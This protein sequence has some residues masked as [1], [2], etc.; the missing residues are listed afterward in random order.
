MNR[1]TGTYFGET[2]ARS[3]CV[4]SLNH[5][6][7]NQVREEGENRRILSRPLLVSGSEVA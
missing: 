3:H 7:A 6:Q 1:D 5:L 2:A 4:L